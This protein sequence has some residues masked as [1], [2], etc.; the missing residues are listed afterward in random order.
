MTE[1]I[2]VKNYVNYKRYLENLIGVDKTQ[3]LIE[4]LGGEERIMNASF[5]MSLDSGSAYDGAFVEN[6]IAISRYAS[7]LNE[8]LPDYMRV[9]NKSI[10]KVALL[11]HIA[12]VVMYEKN[13]NEWEVK[14]R[15]FIYKFIDHDTALRGGERALFI[16]MLVGIV[17]NEDEFE[18]LRIVDKMKEDDAYA[19]FYSNT[20]AFIICQANDMVGTINK[21]SLKTSTHG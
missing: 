18:A 13:D 5:G 21:Q 10:Y 3:K 1:D 15:G 17:L 20:L 8:L 4:L 11:Q 6:V 7:S 16:L 14:N 9:N 19:K 2:K 12:K